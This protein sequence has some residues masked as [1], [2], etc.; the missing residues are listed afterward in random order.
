M[1]DTAIVAS[2]A[3]FIAFIAALIALG[4][5]RTAQWKLA[6]DLYPIRHK[7]YS[8]ILNAFEGWYRQG[9]MDAD[10]HDAIVTS[11]SAARYLFGPDVRARIDLTISQIH[12][13]ANR[14]NRPD[15]KDNPLVA[16]HITEL[17]EYLFNFYSNEDLF[18]PYLALEQKNPR[19]IGFR[20]YQRAPLK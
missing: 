3:A 11:L 16:E 10:R 9:P 1:S 17:Y 8:D 20:R 6:S 4:Q 18:L 2:V 5:W 14:E 12:M 13:L 15:A 7:A 19:S